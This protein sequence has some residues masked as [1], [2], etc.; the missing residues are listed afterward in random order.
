MGLPPWHAAAREGGTAIGGRWTCGT[1][2][3]C[4][5]STTP[6][7]HPLMVQIFQAGAVMVG[8]LKVLEPGAAD[9]W[10]QFRAAEDAPMPIAQ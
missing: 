8:L 9:R 3:E 6:H 1:A 2:S 4:C 10:D 7:P 5:S